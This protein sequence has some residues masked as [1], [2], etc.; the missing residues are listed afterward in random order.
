MSNNLIG[1]G[2]ILLIVLISALYLPRLWISSTD[3]VDWNNTSP[4]QYHTYNMT[5]T[6]ISMG[7]NINMI[8]LII[9][10]FAF[11]IIAF[12]FLLG[13]RGI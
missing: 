1:L 3:G 13:G 2:I 7:T 8:L 10:G 9:I 12:S 5:N 11:V 4:S 6:V